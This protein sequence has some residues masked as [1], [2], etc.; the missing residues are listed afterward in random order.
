VVGDPSTGTVSLD[1][2]APAGGIT[3]NLSSNNAGASVPASVVVQ[4][5]DLSANFPITT[6]VNATPGT[7][8]IRAWT[9]PGAPPPDEVQADLTLR[10][11]GS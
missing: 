8:V 4:E 7:A 1:C 6:D 9:V 3:V 5:G 11:I 2:E 10:A